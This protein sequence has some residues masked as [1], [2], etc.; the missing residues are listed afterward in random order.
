MCVSSQQPTGL[1]E[2]VA[3]GRFREDL[4]HRL[5]VIRIHIPP[6]RERRED[7]GVLMG[8]SCARR[9]GE[10]E[11]EA[12]RLTPDAH[13][14]LQEFS[15]PGNV[16]QLENTA[17]WL[18]VMASGQDIYPQDL[19]P[20]ISAETGES[21]APASAGGD[22]RAM[23]QDWVA[24]SYEAGQ[25]GLLNEVETVMIKAALLATGTAGRKR[26]SCWAG[27]KHADAKAQG[28]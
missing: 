4:F 22:W 20:E 12:K 10:L 28:Y 19:P 6:L 18:T 24:A 15:W 17:R 7:I 27:K 2:Q 1:E 21:G 26:R 23:L 14:R 25:T 3:R 9:P 13:T 8:I 11:V 5:N 16:R